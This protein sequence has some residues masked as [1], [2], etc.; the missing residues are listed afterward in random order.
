MS[1][2]FDNGRELKVEMISGEKIVAMSPAFS[3]HNRVKGNIYAMFDRYLREKPC[4]PFADGENWIV[5]PDK[6]E[7]EIYSLSNGVYVLN[8]LYRIPSEHE[9]PD[10]KDKEPGS[11]PDLTFADFTIDLNEV[12]ANVIKWD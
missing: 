1:E 8:D 2:A 5:E 3:N 12:F 10:I 6:K 11:F 4:L 9:P 7:I